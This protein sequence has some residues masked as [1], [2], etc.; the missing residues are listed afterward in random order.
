[1]IRLPRALLAD[2]EAEAVRLFPDE[3]CGL[4]IGRREGT[5]IRVS[6]IRPSRN[7]AA[8]PRRTFEIDPVLHLQAMREARP[9]G[10]AVVGHY[11]SHP[12]GPAQPS[13]RD[14]ARAAELPYAWMILAATADGVT[15]SAVFLPDADGVLR[16]DNLLLED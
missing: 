5:D 3:C 15:A 13:V 6:V 12:D 16:P 1:V 9:L 4:L 14:T 7:V 2:I 8:D 10:D 11:H